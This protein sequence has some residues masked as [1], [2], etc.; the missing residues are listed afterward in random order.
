M[1]K[2]DTHTRR[3]LYCLNGIMYISSHKTGHGH[4]SITT[5]LTQQIETIDPTVEIND[6]DAF[7]LGGSFTRILSNMYNAFVVKAPLLW[8]LSYKFGDAFPSVIRFFSIRNL[9]SGLLKNIEKFEP[10]LIVVTHPAF[11]GAVLDILEK[12]G[13]NI[14]VVVMIADLDN[15]TRLWADPRSFCTLCPTVNAYRTMRQVG[16]PEE[17]LRVF[18]F[19][20]RDAFNHYDAENNEMPL[21]DVEKKAPT[22]L[23]VNGSQGMG[24]VKKIAER[25]LQSMTCNIIILAGRN[26]KLKDSL[27]KAFLPLYPDRIT[28]CGFTDKV[29]YYISISDVLILRASPNVLM[30]A[31][32]LCKPVI[33]TGALT[34]QEEKNPQFVE[35][36]GLGIVCRDLEKIPKVA[37][38]LF[39]D[40]GRKLL[41]I[42]QAQK[43]FRQPDAAK[44]IATYM[45]DIL[46]GAGH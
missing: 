39:K 46:N 5:A 25:L 27:E 32:N 10:R 22:F 20:V 4:K 44:N 7:L 34:G 38:E 17:R 43:A 12:K 29:D 14:P 45:S 23:L 37:H 8:K 3:R 28:V 19:P 30:E 33:V 15:V 13:L 26:K 18:G 36:N 24:Y 2:Q 9:K 31:V 40:K 41:E 42:V 16:I 21:T 1:K 11:V 35:D 6:L